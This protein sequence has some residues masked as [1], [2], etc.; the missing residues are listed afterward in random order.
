LLPGRSYPSMG[1]N[2]PADAAARPVKIQPDP[3][4]A[5]KGAIDTLVKHFA[6]ALGERGIRV[7]AVAPGRGVN[8]DVELHHQQENDRSAL[9]VLRLNGSSKQ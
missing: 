5:T 4:S 1:A 2:L 9:R 8:R 3:Y 7:N 6:S